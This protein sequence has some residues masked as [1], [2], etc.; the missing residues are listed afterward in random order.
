MLKTAM[1]GKWIGLCLLALLLAVGLRPASALAEGAAPAN[2]FRI[3]IIAVDVSADSAAQA[4]EIAMAQAHRMAFERLFTKLVAEED[5]ALMP[6]LG[7]TELSALVQAVDIVEERTAPTRYLA[8]LAVVFDA[9][10]VRRLLGT[11]GVS[12]A[13]TRSRP[14]L[15][16]PVLRHAGVERLW[17]AENAWLSAWRAY[18]T[19]GSLI[20]FRLPANDLRDRALISARQALAVQPDRLEAVASHYQVSEVL[21]PLAALSRAHP[22]A[23]WTVAVSLTRGPARQPVLNFSVSAEEEEAV[24]DLLARAIAVIDQRLSEAW[25]QQVLV[26]Y[27]Q[28]DRFGARAVFSDFASWRAIQQR[29]DEVA[30]IRALHV[31]GLSITGADVEIEYFGG[32][33]SLTRAIAERGLRLVTGANGQWRLALANDDSAAAAPAKETP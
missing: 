14:M 1:T 30:Q 23:P 33:D 29:L 28:Q 27:G 5:H 2:P 4:R 19:G 16:L 9:G 25:K 3:E 13:E 24:E 6:A 11:L 8:Q 26:Q 22:D 32:W 21:V 12:F 17:G 18:P 31:R 10:A 15:V 20:G 7:D